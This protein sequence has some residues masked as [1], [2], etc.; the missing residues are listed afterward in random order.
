MIRG[1]ILLSARS[2]QARPSFQLTQQQGE[3][4]RVLAQKLRQTEVISEEWAREDLGNKIQAAVA[5]ALE[6]QFSG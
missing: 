2:P 6:Q 1:P 3:G 5:N 4:A